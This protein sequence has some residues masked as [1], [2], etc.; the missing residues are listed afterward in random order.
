MRVQVTDLALTTIETGDTV[1]FVVSS[2]ATGAPVPGAR[3]HVE[4]EVKAKGSPARWETV[5]DTKTDATGQAG[6]SAP[7]KSKGRVTVRRISVEKGNDVLV[8]DPARPPDRYRD[9]HWHEGRGPWLDW[10]FSPLGDRVDA[11]E[12]LVHLFSERPV[13]RPEEDVHLKGYIRQRSSGQLSVVREAGHVVVAAP[14]GAS[15]RL[16]VE[17]TA[18]GSFYARWSESELSTGSYEAWFED[19]AGARLG[20]MS[21]QV[22]AYRLP[23][24]EVD[25]SAADGST[26]VGNDGPFSVDLAASYYAGGAVAARPV[27]WQVTQYPYTWT[28]EGLDGFVY[29][30][31]GRFARSA[32][33]DSTPAI[34]RETTT[35][36]TGGASL[37]LDPGIE[38]NAQPRTYVIEA[39]VTGA[40][41]QTV[42]AVH[43][44][45]AVPSFVL[46]LKVPRYLERDDLIPIEWTVAGPDGASTPGQEV[47]VRLLHRQW[48]SV[49]QSSD[50][51][52]GVA[53]YTTDVVD[54]NVAEQMLTSTD[55]PSTL[56]LPIDEP[57]VYIVEVEA[58][59]RLGRAQFVR[60]DLYAG[61]EGD[62]S[63]SKPE[64]GVFDLSLDAP[65]Y[66]PGDTA[67]LLVRSPFLVGEAL[68]VVEGPT[69]NTYQNVRIRGGKATV[70]IPVEQGWVP[71][72]PVHVLLRR[73]RKEGVPEVAGATDLG[74]PQTVASTAWLRVRPRENTV[75]VALTHPEKAMPGETIPVTVTLTDPDGDPMAGEVTLWLVDQAVL[76]L[77]REQRL[78][79]KPDFITQRQTRLDVHDTRNLAFGSLPFAEM[80]GGDDGEEGDDILDNA[81][82]R[83]DFRPVPYFEPGLMVDASGSA[84]VQV[85]LPD[86]LTVFKIRA[87]AV[88]GEQRFGAGTGSLRVRLPVVVQPD[89]PRFVRPGDSLEVAALGRVVEGKGG[90]GGA[91]VEVEGLL[92]EGSDTADLTW[93]DD[94]VARVAWAVT[95]PTPPAT[96]GGSLSRSIVR[97]KIAARRSEDGASDA[98][99]TILP[100][101]DDRRTVFS[102]MLADLGPG[103]TI[104][105]PGLSEEA[106]AGSVRRGIVLADHPGLVRMAASLDVQVARPARST[107]Q[108]LARAR[109]WLGL[110]NLRE[111]LGLPSGNTQLDQAVADALSWLPSVVDSRG[112]VSAWPGGQG[113]VS[114]AADALSFLTEA[115]ASGYPVDTRLRD[116]LIRAMES[117]LR[118]DYRYFID[119]ESWLERTRSLSALAKA[120]RADRAYLSELERNSRMLGPEGRGRAL[121][122]ATR[123]GGDNSTVVLA[124]AKSAQ[125]DVMVRLV[126]GAQAYGGL[127]AVGTARNPRILP[128]ETR[129][130][131]A[132]TRGL[133]AAEPTAEKLPLMV[134]ALVT[135]GDEDGWGDALADAEAML[136]LAERFHVTERDPVHVTITEGGASVDMSTDDS[137]PATVRTTRH[138]GA[139]VITHT[140]GPAGAI[141]ATTR[142][143]PAAPGS[144]QAAS[145]SGFV[146]ER[147]WIRVTESASPRATIESPGARLRVS[148]GDVIEERIQV[149]NP[150]PRT[151][152]A[153]E[154]PLA[155]GV[156]ILNPAL[157]TAPPEATPTGRTT[158]KPS[159]VQLVDDKA[160]FYYETL[161]KGTFDIAFRTRAT[162][163]GAFVQP[164]AIAELVYDPTVWGCSNGAWVDIQ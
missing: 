155:A 79:P 61:G 103:S 40:D 140:G 28:P 109:T 41:D 158:A 87:K 59:D 142:Y 43:R 98:V 117:A 18:H 72:L 75:G 92:L 106:R 8:L 118:S 6:W 13:Y 42:T 1:Q 48:H 19:A 80:P 46:G 151:Y 20:Q 164:P 111:P 33:F 5:I 135:L 154:V 163:A 100:L 32:R 23:T 49:L 53:R 81:T 128:S 122:A 137:Q 58:R 102:R 55:K 159:W 132:L 60:V 108:R 67:K 120:G 37:V 65:S 91:Q 149:V 7:G 99:E 113:S 129:S 35:D 131:A 112:L 54:V 44:V 157:A 127:T 38:P 22:E 9:G 96:E 86:N 51:S 70:T 90:P 147:S 29:S 62:V 14:G 66:A 25:L 3:V 39:T 63:W 89:L 21:F 68:V 71:R 133:L 52:D 4:A 116:R 31:D 27:R 77:G 107:G 143:V 30:S 26:L 76:S 24:F 83:K 93:R 47:V 45:N 148:I 139:S 88:S 12:T 101:L 95:V 115:D 161:P 130:L 156:E 85:E 162:V 78:D 104:E 119:G 153:V 64:K 97:V 94:D 145:Q 73:G 2:L 84:T 17:V 114:L 82:V 74:K 110:G 125:A 16:P 144:E 11:S 141:F 146:V 105:V 15:W 160:V 123:A 56:E 152:V 10:A 138:L 36:R 57:G 150:E 136:A 50:F 69:G 121:L 34:R 134:D 124:L 126:N